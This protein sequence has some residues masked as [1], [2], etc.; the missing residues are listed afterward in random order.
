GGYCT[1]T[2]G[3]IR[4]DATL[5][6]PD[7]AGIFLA[8]LLPVAVSKVVSRRSA[9]T[10]VLAVNLAAVLAIGLLSTFTRAAWIGAVIGVVAVFA[11]RRGHI[12]I[13]P[14]A[15]SAVVILGG[16]AV[17]AGTVITRPTGTHSSL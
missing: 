12:H 13:W 16:F 2:N 7:S 14:L 10:R 4:A 5:A 1:G 6:N 8:I 15:V 3:V 11:L 9:T 17:L